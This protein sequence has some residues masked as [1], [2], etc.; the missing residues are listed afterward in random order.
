M[1]KSTSAIFCIAYATVSFTNFVLAGT[2]LQDFSTQ[3][4]SC[5]PTIKSSLVEQ[6]TSMGNNYSYTLDTTKIFE[7]RG[8]SKETSVKIPPLTKLNCL[9]RSN[10]KML[11]SAANDVEPY[12]GWVEVKNLL[13]SN[14]DNP[15]NTN[16]ELKPCGIVKPIMI[17]EFCSKMKAM[18]KNVADCAPEQI[19]RSVIKTKFITTTNIKQ[20]ANAEKIS[21]YKSAQAKAEF[22]S[23]NIFNILEVFD[24]A[25]NTQTGDLRLLIGVRGNDLRG[26]IDYN[27][28]NIWYSNLST[29]FSAKGLNSVYQ[30]EVGTQNNDIIAK[31]PKNLNRLLK[32]NAEFTKFPVLYDRRV[33]TN[34]TPPN[35]KP[36]LQIAFIGYDCENKTSASCLTQNSAGDAVAVSLDSADIMFLIDGTK[37]MTEYFNLVSK[38]VKTFTDDYIGNPNYRFG[39]AM[40]GDHKQA[41]RTKITDP[42]D[43]R[44]IKTLQPNSG[45]L[46]ERLAQTELFIKDTKADKEEPVSAAIY[47]AVKKTRWKNN[48]LKFLIHI[49]DHGDRIDPSDLLINLMK[50]K[51]VYYVPI[52]VK[53]DGVISQSNE[54]VRQTNL[55]YQ[56]YKNSNGTSMALPPI[57]TY[58]D[59]INE[60]DAIVKALVGAL[61][62]GR[63]AQDSIYGFKKEL[64]ISNDSI[65]VGFAQLTKAAKELYLSAGAKNGLQTVAAKGWIETVETGE[66]EHNWDYFVMLHTA[67]LLQLKRSMETVCLAIGSSSDEKIIADSIRQLIESLTGDRLTMEDLGN[68]WDDRDSIP[69]VSQTLLGDGI[70]KFLK[71]YSNPEKLKKYKKSFCRGYEL[72]NL[73]QARKKLPEPYEGGSLTWVGDYYQSANAVE[74]R[75][76]YKDFFERSYYYV[77]LT[78]L[79]GWEK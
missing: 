25:R 31:S 16:S 71:D 7:S 44:L 59:K 17:G 78:Y 62:T 68:Y 63:A 8:F 26:W 38:A 24:V 11:I 79:P 45:D 27:A 57:V 1:I 47:N 28:G 66:E 33:R 20:K 40:Y 19:G 41:S 46:F 32:S 39:A 54:F 10:D 35:H 30:S 22:S 49:G 12:C 2:N 74:H 13:E 34:K 43:F 42:L 5:S 4:G 69:L 56:K 6:N 18:G 53:G 76:M 70:K 23:V 60:F 3:T 58:K 65:R 51:N 72:I 61:T 67:E 37:S 50:E 29:Y 73:M 52:A 14:P 48:K 21:L 75:W 77:P 36:Q 9:I 55:I 15:L 64:D